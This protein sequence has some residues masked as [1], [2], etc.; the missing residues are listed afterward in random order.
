MRKNVDY[1]NAGRYDWTLFTAEDYKQYRKILESLPY[2]PKLAEFFH[3][4][5]RNEQ[6]WEKQRKRYISDLECA[7]REACLLPA[8][9]VENEVI[10]REIIGEAKKRLTGTEY[11]RLRK[12]AVMGLSQTEIAKGERVALPTVSLC[13]SSARRKLSKL[14]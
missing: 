4:Q 8:G 3:E 11:R 1:A 10:F 14:G 12:H 6:R 13:I 9:N 5:K 7:D 2:D